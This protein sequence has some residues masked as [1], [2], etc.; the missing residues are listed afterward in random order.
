MNKINLKLLLVICIFISMFVF[1]CHSE[2]TKNIKNGYDILIPSE[3]FY[4]IKKVNGMD[5]FF[6]GNLQTMTV[7]VKIGFQKKIGSKKVSVLAKIYSGSIV[8]NTIDGYIKLL[9]KNKI[10][11]KVDSNKPEMFFAVSESPP[12]LSIFC[13]EVFDV[14]KGERRI[15]ATCRVPSVLERDGVQFIIQRMSVF[16][17]KKINIVPLSVQ[18][19]EKFEGNLKGWFVSTNF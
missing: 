4:G 12:L 13:G 17:N 10:A 2:G 19:S 9:P 5:K 16:K 7:N 8:I 3:P 1:A 14:E 15:V 18:F 6:D 11:I